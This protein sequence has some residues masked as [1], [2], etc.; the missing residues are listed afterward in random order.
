MELTKILEG[1]E[2]LSVFGKTDLNIDLVEY[3]SRKIKP[4]TMFVCVKGYQT[5]GHKFIEQAIGQ[6]AEC[7][8][9]QDEVET[10]EGITYIRVRDTRRDLA[11]IATNLYDNPAQKLRLVG[12]T[13]TKGKTTTTYMIKSILEEVENQIGLI[14]TIQN[15]V[16]NKIMPATRT[17]PESSDL[18]KFFFDMLELGSK[19]GVMEVSSHAIELHRIKN[20]EFE[21]G[22]FT[23]LGRDH[24]DFHN[25]VENYLSAK[26]KLF[27]QCQNT[28]INIDNDYGQEVLERAQGKKYTFGI[29]NRADIMAK[30]IKRH[31]EQVEFTVETPWGTGEFTVNIPGLFSVYN[32]LAAIGSGLLLGIP[33]EKIKDGLSKAKVPGRAEVIDIGRDFSIMIDYAHTPDSLQNIL[34]TVK[35]FTKGRVISV[36]GCGGDRDKTKRP[37]MGKVSGEVADYSIITSDNPRSE[38]PTEIIKDIEVGIKDTKGDYEIVVERK[39]AILQA[40]KIAKKEDVIVVSGKGHETYQI[41]KDKTIDFDEKVIIKELNTEL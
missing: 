28:L 2:I 12:V 33:M 4:G 5:D 39:A 19:Y 6:G 31:R 24:L 30:N 3:D 29:N 32:S 21:V 25:S 26:I 11:K 9:I 36:F 16:G 15:S 23:N 8:L 7:I 40:M 41:F 27:E 20:V 18:Q 10:K 37:L 14:G 1:V 17:T 34:S 38:E 35:E 13:G 22:I